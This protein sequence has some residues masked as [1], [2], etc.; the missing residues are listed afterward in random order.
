[1]LPALATIESVQLPS[2]I[3]GRDGTNRA[4]G[5]RPQIAANHDVDAIKAWLA[6]FLDTKTTFDNYR[7]EAERLLLWSTIQLSKPLSSLTPI[8]SRRHS[9]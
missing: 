1:M 5:N 4:T 7:K 9:G 3:D 2:H 8:R 6:R